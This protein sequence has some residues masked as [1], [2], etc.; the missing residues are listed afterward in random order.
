MSGPPTWSDDGTAF[1]ARRHRHPALHRPRH[2]GADRSRREGHLARQAL[3]RAG[4][5]RPH[6]AARPRGRRRR[7]RHLARRPRRRSS[8]RPASGAGA[9]GGDDRRGLAAVAGRARGALRTDD[10]RTRACGR[11]P[12]ARAQRRR[13]HRQR[14]RHAGAVGPP[15][16]ARRRRQRA[17]RA[18]HRRADRARRRHDRGRAEP[19]PR[20]ARH[21]GL[22]GCARGRVWGGGRSG[23]RHLSVWSDGARGPDGRCARF[24]PDAGRA[25]CHR[26]QAVRQAHR[27]L[28]GDPAEPRG[29][30]GQRRRLRHRR[31]VRLPRRRAQRRPL[32]DRRRQGTRRRGGR[33]RRRHRPPDTRRHRLHLRALAALR[34]APPLVVA[35]RVRQRKRVGPPAR[36][37]R[38]RARGRRVVEGSHRPLSAVNVRS[39]GHRGT[40]PRWPSRQKRVTASCISST[41]H[42]VSVGRELLNHRHKSTSPRAPPLVLP[43]LCQAPG[44]RPLARR[45][46]VIK[47]STSSLI[48]PA[49]LLPIAAVVSLTP[50]IRDSLAVHA[51][52]LLG[53]GV[54]AL[55]GVATGRGRLVLGLMVLALTTSALINFGSRI[56][57]YA[58]ALLLPLNLGVIAWLGETRAFSVRGASWL[59]VILLQAGAVGIL[60][61]L[62]PADLGASLE[63]PLV[64]VDSSAWISVPQIAVFAF[65]AMLGAHLARF[66]RSRRPLPAGAVGAL[67]ASFLALDT[68]GSGGPADLHFATAGMLLALGTVLEAPPVFHFDIV[69]GLP[70][71]LEFNKMVRPLPRRS[72]LACVAIDEVRMFSEDLGVE[73]ANRML[74][75]VAKALTK[76]GGGGHVFYLLRD[77]E[78]V[79][80][81]PRKSVEAAAGYLNAVRRAVE[82]ASLDVSV[83]QPAKAGHKALGVV[84]RTV[85]GTISA[86]V[87]EPQSRAADPF[88]VLREAELALARAQQTG[89]NRIVVQPRPDASTDVQAG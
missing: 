67:V 50:A 17:G 61:L 22:Q 32:R 87:A 49:L 52:P 12:D 56:T 73:V 41:T 63:R 85:A 34:H 64:A 58:V 37:R 78:F 48:A 10:A 40:R 14:A 28:S 60:E 66:V 42:S 75:L 38:G 57:F 35:R 46:A 15:R 26:A 24:V 33:R 6:A 3:A 7:R 23:G 71:S 59:G 18:A 13:R 80:V 19:R 47:R 69:T 79:V 74:R 84:K 53:F 70:A 1:P 72:A 29:A 5:G 44:G 31:R 55:L 11:A 82:A 9:A 36:P 54:G 89:M 83:A 16:G 39:V 65:A 43:L 8:L 86:G 2:Q 77:H 4:R 21:A 51:A 30:R 81:F 25:V 20:A 76:I 45:R 88:N 62:Q 68:A 27:Q